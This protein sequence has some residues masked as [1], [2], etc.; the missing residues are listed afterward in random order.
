MAKV[1][2]IVYPNRIASV[3]PNIVNRSFIR[4]YQ[5]YRDLGKFRSTSTGESRSTQ[6][7]QFFQHVLRRAEG[8]NNIS[9]VNKP[10]APNSVPFRQLLEALFKR[11]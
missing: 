10:D 6:L 4:H 7:Q 2:S 1:F 9:Q 3:L 8:T 11:K 5:P